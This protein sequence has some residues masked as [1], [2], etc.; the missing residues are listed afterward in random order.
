MKKTFF[1]DSLPVSKFLD[2]Y[3]SSSFF[4]WWLCCKDRPIDFV[5]KLVRIFL[6]NSNFPAVTFFLDGRKFII[7]PL[8]CDQSRKFLSQK[9]IQKTFLLHSSVPVLKFFHMWLEVLD[10]TCHSI[11]WLSVI[12]AFCIMSLSEFLYG[13]RQRDNVNKSLN[14]CYITNTDFRFLSWLLDCCFMIN[15]VVFLTK[16]R[17]SESGWME[18][19]EITS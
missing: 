18:T 10:P 19:F 3:V 16:C 11:S 17:T 13:S 4:F 8:A 15:I 9:K 14:I 12:A 5:F 1:C 6:L 2:R 7:F